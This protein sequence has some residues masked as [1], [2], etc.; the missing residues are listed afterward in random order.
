MACWPHWSV[1]RARPPK[2]EPRD[3][4]TATVLFDRANVTVAVKVVDGE[5]GSDSGRNTWELRRRSA[6]PAAVPL[7]CS[8][9]LRNPTGLRPARGRPG[10]FWRADRVTLL[11]ARAGVIVDRW[12]VSSSRSKAPFRF[13]AARV[14]HRKSWS[15]AFD[16]GRPT[17]TTSTLIADGGPP[18]DRPR[19][20]GQ[21]A[22]VVNVNGDDTFRA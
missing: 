21:R 11:Q 18:V 1:R 17:L 15:R 7:S 20:T 3:A 12:H 16:S 19:Q 13:K 22:L 14:V 8:A 10:Y 5:R 2:T 9:G 6:G 4:T